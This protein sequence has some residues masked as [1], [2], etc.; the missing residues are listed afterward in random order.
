VPHDIPASTAAQ[1]AW[2]RNR[3]LTVAELIAA[4]TRRVRSLNPRYRAFSHL[5]AMADDDIARLQAELDGGAPRGPLHG[6]AASVKGNI[7]AAG[8]P[9]TEGSALFADRVADV[10]AAIVARLRAAGAL[11]LGTTTLSELAMYGTTN[12]F[13]PMGLNPWDIGRTAGGSST[14]AGVAA[15][16]GLALVNIGTDSGGSIR[17][18]ACHCGVVGLMPRRA[19]LPHGGLADYTPSLSTVGLIGR[20]VADVMAAFHVLAAV[21]SAASPPAR[22]LV[23]Q[24]LIA[25]SADDATLAL[26]GAAL[27]RLSAAGIVVV[28]GAIDGWREGEAAAATLSL[29]ESGQALARMDLARAGDG[30]RRR[31]EAAARLTAA[32]AKAA[33][34]AMEEFAG[35]FDAA[36]AQVGA[37]A[38]ATPT[39]PFAAPPIDA[40]TVAVRGR[41]V[42]VDPARNIFVR[43]A[44]ALDAAAITLPMGLYPDVRVPAGL[45]LTTRGGEGGL[46]ALAAQIEAALPALPPLAA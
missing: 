12:A 3:R 35:R 21:A 39:W 34:A 27:E 36:L 5:A 40:A 44:N 7:P 23:P 26:F 17:N 8:L 45:Q 25:E 4:H 11:L 18:P 28:A 13:E 42:P 24:D 33:R 30:I 31:A 1:G 38:V 29:Y 19:T 32:Q 10:D 16:L 41:A 14:G 15:A 22:L 46:L 20:S 9:W 37:T 6:I 43:A 2:L